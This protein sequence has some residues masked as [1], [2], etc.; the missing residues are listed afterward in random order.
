M[1]EDTE[2][3]LSKLNSNN[4]FGSDLYPEAVSLAK[5]S[6]KKAG[7]SDYIQVEQG[8]AQKISPAFEKGTLF[9]NPP[10]GE[11]M[12][13]IEN[14]EKLYYNLG[15]NLKNNFKASMPGFSRVIQT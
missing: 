6:I 15:E 3:K 11:R 10:Y 12:G 8:D 14:L 9:C 1:N 4:F 5:K 2:A 13:E 7:L